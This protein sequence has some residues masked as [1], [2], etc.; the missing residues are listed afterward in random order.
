M[1]SLMKV[2]N[3]IIKIKNQ[4]KILVISNPKQTITIRMCRII[5]NKF[6]RNPKKL[7][8]VIIR[9]LKKFK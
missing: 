7:P 9:F 6:N 1:L 8:I 2:T 4:F 3:P 5:S